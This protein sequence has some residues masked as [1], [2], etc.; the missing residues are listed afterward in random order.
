M[1]KKIY[2]L[3]AKDAKLGRI[4]AKAAHILMG[5]DTVAFARNIAPRVNVHILNASSVLVESRKL[6][7]KTYVSYSGYP[8]GLK[9]KSM[10]QTA[11]KKGYSE[12]FRKAVKGMLPK[13]RLQSVMMNNLKIEE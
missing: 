3:D 4:A 6:D 12:V 9:K 13:N 2:K 8:G 11:I 5:K 7:G 1:E 10:R